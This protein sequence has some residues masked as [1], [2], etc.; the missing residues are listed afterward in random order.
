MLDILAGT[1][2][3]KRYVEASRALTT[4]QVKVQAKAKAQAQARNEHLMRTCVVERKD[5]RKQIVNSRLHHVQ[6]S[7]KLVT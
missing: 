2:N 3:K 5:T 6:N 1:K 4:D 7:E